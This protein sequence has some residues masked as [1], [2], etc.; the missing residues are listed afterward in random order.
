MKARVLGLIGG[1]VLLSL[2][3]PADADQATTTQAPQAVAAST[4]AAVLEVVSDGN[5]G[6]QDGEEKR[7]TPGTEQSQVKVVVKDG[8]QYLVVVYMAGID[9]DKDPEG[10]GPYSIEC[11]SYEM[12]ATSAPKKVAERVRLVADQARRGGNH[13]RIAPDENGN[14]LLV[15][16]SD[17]MRDRPSAYAM[18]IDN[19]CRVLAPAVKF[20]IANSDSNDGAADVVP[21]PGKGPNGEIRFFASYLS[22]NG[23]PAPVAGP[24]TDDNNTWAMPITVKPQGAGLY[25]IAPEW[26]SV[27]AAAQVTLDKDGDPATPETVSYP[28]RTTPVPLVL[29]A[30]IGRPTVEMIDANRGLLCAAEGR[31]RPPAKGVRCVVFDINSGAVKSSAIV[32]PSNPDQHIYQNQPTIA[33]LDA[34]HY[35][36]HT[37]F[38]NGRG[39]ND[40]IKGQNTSETRIL[41]LSGDTL[42]ENTK[43]V[44]TP[45]HQTH[46]AICTGMQGEQSAPT[47][48]VISASPTGIGRSALRYV[49]FDPAAKKL[50]F[51][52]TNDTWPTA[53]Y[54]DSGHLSNWYG[55]N[56]M[57]QG[58][59]FV[60][61]V[62]NVKNPGYGLDGGYMKDVKSFFVTS[63]SGRVPGDMKN[64]LFMSLVPAEVDH[65]AV[66]ENPK[67]ADQVTATNAPPAAPNAPPPMDDAKGCACS[68]P[69]HT[70]S[71]DFGGGLLL[72]GLAVGGIVS[73]RRS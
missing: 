11:T 12:Q 41:E 30:N 27:D 3:A 51:D 70:S 2:A 68:T 59:D 6:R 69:G 58:R 43:M 15:Y 20:S 47:I 48:G 52:A 50:A 46:S 24:D 9:K 54:G 56:P 1:G 4:S 53:W 25:Q 40:N 62:G 7:R 5:L 18:Y 26:P 23:G 63:V 13:P 17:Y 21:I 14:L 60:R 73:R 49:H 33:K 55:E 16:G 72:L 65:V 8:K 67:P 45:V 36:L 32:A 29:G 34:T 57:N 37:N 22:T 61:C 42:L 66:P 28:A 19:A 10:R 35:V 31:N 44:G 64:R 38:T 71:S 39:K